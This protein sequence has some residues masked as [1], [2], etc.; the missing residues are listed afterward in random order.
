[1]HDSQTTRVMQAVLN[2]RRSRWSPSGLFVSRAMRSA[3]LYT[4]SWILLLLCRQRDS[5]LA[6]HD[7]VTVTLAVE[8][9]RRTDPMTGYAKAASPSYT[10]PRATRCASFPSSFGEGSPYAHHVVAKYRMESPPVLVSCNRSTI[11]WYIRQSVVVSAVVI[12]R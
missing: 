11:C 10:L 2:R 6:V 7:L 4:P 12:Q 1:M 5:A 3:I 8:N 9:S